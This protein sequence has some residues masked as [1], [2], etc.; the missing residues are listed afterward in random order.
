M[1]EVNQVWITHAGR[2]VLIVDDPDNNDIHM[3]WLDEIDGTM[4]VSPA[5]DRLHLRSNLS[6]AQLFEKWAEEL[7]NRE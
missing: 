7:T 4:T 1:P 2:Y 3:L 5:M 6:A